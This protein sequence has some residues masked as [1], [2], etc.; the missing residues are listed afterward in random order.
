MA[1]V[2]SAHAATVSPSEWAPKF[3]T[4]FT[5]WQTVITEKS[6][7]MTAAFDAKPTKG[8]SAQEILGNARDEIAGFL[9]DMVGATNDATSAIKDAGIPSSPNGAKISAVFVNGFKDI[10]QKFAK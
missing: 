3:C 7:E 9:S 5:N 2:G 10:S 4:A 6:D 8:Q 1:S